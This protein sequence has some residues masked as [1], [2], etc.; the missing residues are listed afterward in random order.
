ME[1]RSVLGAAQG[2]GQG[3][4]LN[5]IPSFSDLGIGRNLAKPGVY[6]CR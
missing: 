1:K 5:V 3:R 4:R 2:C 6:D